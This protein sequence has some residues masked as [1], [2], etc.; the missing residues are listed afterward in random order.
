MG[1]QNV[2]DV[3]RSFYVYVH[4][5]KLTG[6]PFYVGKGRRKRAFRKDRGSDWKQRVRS[7]PNGYSI[8]IAQD[9]LTEDEAYDLECE[10]IQKY[11]RLE[12]GS[13]TLINK[14]L[15]GENNLGITLAFNIPGLEN[16]NDETHLRNLNA[17]EEQELLE[18]LASKMG[19]F[20]SKFISAVDEEESD[21]EMTVGGAISLVATS[22]K[23]RAK[24]RIS[25]RDLAIVLEEAADDVELDLED[26]D[27]AG[28]RKEVLSLSH[29]IMAFLKS[30]VEY[31]Q[32]GQ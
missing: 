2:E 24:K 3:D 19:E 1:S 16:L 6:V 13:G 28:E 10:L 4:K 12:N 20:Q 17:T 14:S 7:L 9:N 8:E 18:C 23:K 31:L 29:E 27:K 22:V 30:K 21:L 32:S 26:A 5:D 25:Y 15:G 11:G